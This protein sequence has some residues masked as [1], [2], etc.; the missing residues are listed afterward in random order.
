MEEIV[1]LFCHAI[2][3]SQVDVDEVAKTAHI[4]TLS[5]SI[6]PQN[7]V[8]Q[9]QNSSWFLSVRKPGSY[10][11]GDALV[12]CRKTDGKY[13]SVL[14]I[15]EEFD[16]IFLPISSQHLLIGAVEIPVLDINPEDINYASARTSI[17][18]FIAS[19]NTKREGAYQ[20]ELG[21]GHSVFL[22]E[23]ILEM[24][25]IAKQHWIS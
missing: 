10:I 17:D 4:D 8:A 16:Y 11:L 1:P 15:D 21:I 18:F 12:V 3:P 22:D 9:F 24:T 7:R 2:S 19:Q 20:K 14:S 6:E 25:T 5:K 23:K 13:S